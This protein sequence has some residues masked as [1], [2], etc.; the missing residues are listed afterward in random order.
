MSIEAIAALLGHKTLAMTMVYARI[1]DKIVADEDFSVT[2]KVEALYDRPH[3][4]P[5][6]DEGSEMRRVRAES[7]PTR[8]SRA[9]SPTHRD[10][11]P[12]SAMPPGV[13][14]CPRGGE[15]TARQHR[16]QPRHRRHVSLDRRIHPVRVA[17]AAS[18]EQS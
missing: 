6:D 3:Q 8:K 9:W 15:R 18:C 17:D 4:V 5:A 13:G 11:C 14:Y 2:E 16:I 1:A 7:R 12:H 10:S